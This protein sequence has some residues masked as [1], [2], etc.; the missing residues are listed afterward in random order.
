[1]LVLADRDDAGDMRRRDIVISG[2]ARGRSVA[3]CEEQVRYDVWRVDCRW[4]FLMQA[5][6][7]KCQSD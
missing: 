1:M 7:G 3:G 5:R 6:W 2:V 4:I